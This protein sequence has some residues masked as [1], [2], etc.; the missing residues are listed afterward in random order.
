MIIKRQAKRRRRKEQDELNLSL[1][2]LAARAEK[3]ARAAGFRN[4]EE[5][6]RKLEKGELDGT[7]VE[8][9]LRSIRFLQEAPV[10][11]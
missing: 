7:I 6:F 1:E 10:T 2:E 3:I 4:A 9:R 8:A 11:G 5:A